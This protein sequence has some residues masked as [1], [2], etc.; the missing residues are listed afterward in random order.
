MHKYD[1]E[2]FQLAD[3]LSQ[4]QW[5]GFNTVGILTERAPSQTFFTRP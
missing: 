4:R 2:K 1:G 3:R 5:S